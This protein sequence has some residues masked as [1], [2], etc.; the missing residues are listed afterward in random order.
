VAVLATLAFAPSLGNDFVDW[1][2]EANLTANP[3][4]RGLGWQQVRWMFTSAHVLGHWIPLTWLSFGADYVLWGMNPVGYH[5]TNMLLHAA[6]AALFTLLCLRLLRLA[7]PDIA[8]THARLGAAA[9]ALFWALHPLR[10]ESV[11][12]ATE[13]RDLLSG[14]LFLLSVLAYVRMAAAPAPRRWRWLGASLAAFA[15][16]L[17]SKP[18]VMT[19]PVVLL[20]LDVYP[21]RRL[22]MPARHWFS[23]P[24]RSVLVEKGPYVALAGVGGAISL[25]LT[26]SVIPM[27]SVSA[28]PL[29]ARLAMV[30]NSLVFYIGKTLMPVGLVPVHEAPLDASLAQPRYLVAA[31]LTVAITAGL[32][33]LRRRCPGALAA[34]CVY[35]VILLPV[36]N[37]VINIDPQIV[38]DRYS[39]LSCL[40]WAVLAG[41]AVAILARA[42]AGSAIRPAIGKAVV[43]VIALWLVALAALT[44][45]Q[46]QVWHDSATLW[47]HAVA[48]SP[49]C[50]LCENRL[51]AALFNRRD[52]G[53]AVAH[54]ERAVLLRPDRPHYHRELGVAFLW[55][56]RPAEAIP[57]LRLALDRAP[58]DFDLRSSLG[59]ALL[60]ANRASEAE[61][62]FRNVVTRRPDH[63]DGLAGLGMTLLA[64]GRPAES[65]ALRSRS[66]SAR[67]RCVPARPSRA[68]VWR[69]PTW[70]SGAATPPRPR[71]QS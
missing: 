26:A 68:T 69:A 28:Y 31:V 2:D 16:A 8:V 63:P 7:M 39:Y 61:I 32:V 13:R 57:R 17:L 35:V 19:L 66:S 22:G 34:W 33:A 5:L 30:A 47:T 27:A 41:A 1:D 21:L 70:R 43:A 23:A 50:A 29:T 46:T 38:A 51:G 56:N 6:N 20:V 54:L 64:L 59:L 3:D 10:V 9:G 53:P 36:S 58:A 15:A 37:L 60:W 11:A 65:V 45:Q 67:W 49:D 55:T 71:R 42:T 62:E 52:L 25:T 14:L 40:P 12:W 44:W 18:I 4:Y 48:V 24:A